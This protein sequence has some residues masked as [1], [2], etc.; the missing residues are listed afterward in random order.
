[1]IA[2]TRAK[3]RF[4]AHGMIGSAA[5]D[6]FYF[7]SSWVIGGGVG[8]DLQVGENVDIRVFKADYL[9]TFFFEETQRNFRVSAGVSVRLGKR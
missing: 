1:M 7:Y 2:L 8:Y 9:T 3:G 6:A 5:I 4:F